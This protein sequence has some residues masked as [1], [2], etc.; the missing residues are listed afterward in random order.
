MKRWM[1]TI[2]RVALTCAIFTV[3]IG[4]LRLFADINL[5][6]NDTTWIMLVSVVLALILYDR[7]VAR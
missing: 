1:P 4:S 2:Q 5:P 6:T 7:E 3:I